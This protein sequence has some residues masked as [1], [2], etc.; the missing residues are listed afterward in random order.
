MT[1]GETYELKRKIFIEKTEKHFQ[2]LVSEFE[3]KKPNIITHDYSDK[4]EFE[5]EIT[6]KKITILNSYHPVDYGFEIILTDLKTGR[7]EML[8]YV[9]KGDQ[10]IEQNYLESASEFLKNGFGIRLRGK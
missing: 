8:H 6:K 5:N 1:P 10:D 9:L 4:F 2:F 7:E 3:F